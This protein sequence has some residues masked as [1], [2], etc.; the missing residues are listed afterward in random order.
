MKPRESFG[1]EQELK[2]NYPYVSVC[3]SDDPW[4]G[5][6]G[7]SDPR[8]TLCSGELQQHAEMRFNSKILNIH[9]WT[10]FNCIRICKK[11]TAVPMILFV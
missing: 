8:S 3:E 5:V 10:T 2:K 7:K 6:G 1:F 11:L 9:Y 4:W